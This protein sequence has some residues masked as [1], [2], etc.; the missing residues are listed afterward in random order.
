MAA[1][2]ARCAPIPGAQQRR[3]PGPSQPLWLLHVLHHDHPAAGGGLTMCMNE[4]IES[5][6]STSIKFRSHF[7]HYLLSSSSPIYFPLLIPPPPSFFLLLARSCLSH[8]CFHFLSSPPSDSDP[9][10]PL[11]VHWAGEDW[12]DLL[13]HQRHWS[14]RWG[15]GHPRPVQGP[16]HHRGPGTDPVHLLRQDRH[17][18]GEQDGVSQVLHHG[19]RVPTQREW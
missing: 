19:H 8:L 13:H 6:F 10:L 1:G 5:D 3:S 18:H 9:H 12:S 4:S 16:E 7:L 15:V 17:S 2:A 11:L 14:V